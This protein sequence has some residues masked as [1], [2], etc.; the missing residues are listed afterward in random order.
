[1]VR[2]EQLQLPPVLPQ[3]PGM[4]HTEH[5]P[6][7]PALPGQDQLLHP[8]QPQPELEAG[9]GAHRHHPAVLGVKVGKYHGQVLSSVSP[10]RPALSDCNI[11]DRSRKKESCQKESEYSQL[12]CFYLYRGGERVQCFCNLFTRGKFH[13]KKP[14]LYFR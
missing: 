10:R 14:H 6:A 11:T 9:G 5:Q 1:M 7:V 8:V 3:Q 12:T 2:G 4:R 13:N